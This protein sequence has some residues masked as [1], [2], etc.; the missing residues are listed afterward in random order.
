MRIGGLFRANTTGR[1]MVLVALDDASPR[2]DGVL[3][4]H[5]EYTATWLL[6]TGEL[7]RYGMS[8]SWGRWNFEPVADNDC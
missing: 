6:P 7:V 8:L 1:L 3:Y 2:P 5:S 4:D